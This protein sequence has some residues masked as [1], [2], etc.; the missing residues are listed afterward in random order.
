MKRN[1]IAT[2]ALNLAD[3]VECLAESPCGVA[4]L[5]DLLGIGERTVRANLTR[6]ERRGLAVVV[7]ARCYADG[8]RPAALWGRA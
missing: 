7:G 3:I 6:A 1:D 8:H 4:D 5:V 2:G